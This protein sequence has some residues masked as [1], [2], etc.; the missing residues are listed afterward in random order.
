[1]CV[2]L[3]LR[4]ACSFSWALPTLE[5]ISFIA[6]QP[7]SRGRQESSLRSEPVRMKSRRAGPP[8][9][10]FGWVVVMSAFFIMGLTTGVFKNFGHFFLDIQCHFGVP[11]STTSW[12]SST[13]IAMFHLGGTDSFQ[14]QLFGCFLLKI[15]IYLFLAGVFHFLL[16]SCGQCAGCAVFSESGHHSRRPADCLWDDSGIS[17]PQSALALPHYGRP[18]R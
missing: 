9:R 12:V 18:A 6:W 14:L 4:F 10:G 16:S 17:G 15:Y 11:T 2:W 5:L 8:R 3:Y 7:L 13:T 1:M